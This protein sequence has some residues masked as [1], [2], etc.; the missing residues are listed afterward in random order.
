MLT[1]WC[2]EISDLRPVRVTKGTN[3]GGCSGEQGTKAAGIVPRVGRHWGAP[4]AGTASPACSEAS[5]VVPT[6]YRGIGIPA[7]GPGD[8]MTHVLSDIESPRTSMGVEALKD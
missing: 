8:G 2:R 1:F 3:F 7:G 4:G 6:S 5:T